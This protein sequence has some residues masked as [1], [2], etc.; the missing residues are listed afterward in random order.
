MNAAFSYLLILIALAQ[1]ETPSAQ[2]TLSAQ[3][4]LR[5]VAVIPQQVRMMPAQPRRRRVFNRHRC[6]GKASTVPSVRRSLD[7]GKT[8]P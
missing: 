8:S 6:D 4:P 1:Y 5:I 3:E 7:A 2:T